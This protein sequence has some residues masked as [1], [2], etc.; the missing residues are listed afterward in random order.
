MRLTEWASVL[1]MELPEDDPLRGYYTCRLADAC[2]KGGYGHRYWMPRWALTAVL[3]YVE[4]PRAR[5]VRHAQAAGRYEQV[6][7]LRLVLGRQGSRLRIA[8]LDGRETEPPVNALA[9]SS[10]RRLFRSTAL[11]LEPAVV[12]LNED[13]LPRDPHGWH[14][15]FA[16]AN[17][18]IS[19]LG[20]RGFRAA[21]HHLRHSFAL[22]WYSVGRM[23]YERRFGHLDVEEQK[24]F[25]EQFGNTWD[26][27][28]TMLGH[29]SPETAKRHYLEP[30]RGLE[31]ELLLR[32][33]SEAAVDTFLASYLADHPLVHG[34]PLRAA[35]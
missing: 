5:A 13:G 19:G 7:G 14:H 3:A 6:R 31:V 32:H 21:P 16:A 1:L 15:T 18:R 12:W 9:P 17:R 35:R 10:R 27:V 33:A 22:R 23:A 24:D 11:G 30:F 28:A 8:E 26:L 25:R 2:A 4:G 29:R 34:D 20:L